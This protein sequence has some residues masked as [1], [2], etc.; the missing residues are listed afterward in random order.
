MSFQGNILG[1]INAAGN[2]GKTIK[3][4]QAANALIAKQKQAMQKVEQAK[5][6]KTEQRKRRD[7]TKYIPHLLEESGYKGVR[8]NKEQ[9]K[10]VS[11]QY[12][13]QQKTEI[14]NRLDKSTKGGI[15]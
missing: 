3:G 8:L 4:I 14:M 9:L 12:T 5:A 2:V 15:K 13:K 10:H 7:F 1:A 11:G 6:A